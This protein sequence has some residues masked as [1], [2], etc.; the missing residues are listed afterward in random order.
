MHQKPSEKQN[1]SNMKA[2]NKL[3]AEMTA[4]KQE[5]ASQE[6]KL[7]SIDTIRSLNKR[8]EQVTDDASSYVGEL[9][10]IADRMER[11]ID[12]SKKLINEGEALAGDLQ[13]ELVAAEKAA[14]DLGIDP[15]SIKELE[16]GMNIMMDLGYAINE[17]SDY[18]RKYS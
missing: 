17:L 2:L 3:W 1:N 7:G 4:P 9:M 14:S 11:I 6:V 13:R 5:L 16:D 12:D 15:D 8:A 18:H 10:D